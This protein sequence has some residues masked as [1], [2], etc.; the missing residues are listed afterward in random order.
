MALHITSHG[1]QCE[2][3]CKNLEDAMRPSE[4]MIF[5]VPSSHMSIDFLDL[6]IE[7]HKGG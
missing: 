3:V 4:I 1:I 7:N 6:I 2:I 5:N